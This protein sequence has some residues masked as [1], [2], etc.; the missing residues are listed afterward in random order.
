MKGSRGIIAAVWCAGCLAA[1]GWGGIAAA[2]TPPTDSERLRQ[3][4]LDLCA[5]VNDPSRRAGKLTCD[6]AQ[7]W[8]KE[9]IKTAVEKGRLSWPFGDARC[10]MKVDIARSLLAPAATEPG[11]KLN[12]TPQ[13]VV[14]AVDT[15]SGPYEV[16]AKLAPVMKFEKGKVTSVD[17]GIKDIEGGAVVR[18]VVWAAW[19]F[20]SNFG[21]FQEDFVRLANKYVHEHCPEAGKNPN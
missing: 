20:E 12:A 1:T 2:Q 13:P 9:D 19:K 15:E 8:Y 7:T 16:K 10:T 17:L 21:F 11:Y 5:I 18:N 14:C 3:C 4:D 6:I